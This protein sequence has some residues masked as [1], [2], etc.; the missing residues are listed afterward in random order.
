MARFA[1][2]RGMRFLFPMVAWAALT[3]ASVGHGQEKVGRVVA[4]GDSLTA[5]YGLGVEQA[6]PAL[7]QQKIEQASLNYQVINAGVS[8]DTSAGGLRRVEWLLKEPI[9][10]LILGLGGNDG[11][12][13]LPPASTQDNL[14]QIIGKVRARNPQVRVLVLGMRM[15]SNFGADYVALYTAIFPEV[16]RQGKATLVPF[17]LEG[18]GGIAALNQADRIHPN[19]EGQKILAAT[20]WKYLEPVLTGKEASVEK[21]KVRL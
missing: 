9:D 13:G 18:V 20:V 6:Y 7:L 8:G 2:I 1:D 17:L 4:L 21:A 10:V 16:A 5:G 11:L 3:G 12:R 19:E 15:P 14:L